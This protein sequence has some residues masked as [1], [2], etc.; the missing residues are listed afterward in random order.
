[1]WESSE[2]GHQAR[3]QR[4]AVAECLGD[5]VA[6][7][8]H[9]LQQGQYDEGTEDRGTGGSESAAEN[10]R[11]PAHGADNAGTHEQACD[12]QD[13]HA[14]D[15]IVVP[16]DVILIQIDRGFLG[17]E[18]EHGRGKIRRHIRER[19]THRP[20]EIASIIGNGIPDTSKRIESDCEELSASCGHRA[21]VV[22][23]PM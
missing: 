11:V 1:M 4:C 12:N 19:G 16:D 10:V 13:R 18:A 9:H 3:A 20:Q 6:G 17:G 5:A 2:L 14:K 23:L 7:G 22:G 21:H 15:D 8:K